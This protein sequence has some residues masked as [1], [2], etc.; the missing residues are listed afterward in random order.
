MNKIY[1]ILGLLLVIIV[2][3]QLI[4]FYLRKKEK[5]IPDSSSIERM[6]TINQLLRS[7]F[8]INW[9]IVLSLIII[10]IIIILI[11]MYFLTKKV[12]INL[13][14]SNKTAIITFIIITILSIILI[15]NIYRKSIPTYQMTEDE[16]HLQK[17]RS[18]IIKIIVGVVILVFLILLGFGLK[19]SNFKRDL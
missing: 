12:D 13:Q 6:Q 16:K 11:I 5:I 2:I 15:L 1:I 10:L 9:S 17:R 18:N 3:I 14:I 8:G 19:K 7:Y 4:I